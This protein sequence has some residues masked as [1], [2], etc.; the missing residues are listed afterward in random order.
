[1]VD[2]LRDMEPYCASDYYVRLAPAPGRLVL[3]F[4]YS[5][6]MTQVPGFTRMRKIW[7][8]GRGESLSRS[9]G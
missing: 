5:V 1:M 8:H 7:C 6:D 2:S 9:F 4:S 3:F